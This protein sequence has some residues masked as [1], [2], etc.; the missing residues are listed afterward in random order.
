MSKLAVDD[1][2]GAMQAYAEM[3][4]ASDRGGPFANLGLADIALFNGDFA[5]AAELLKT[6]VSGD[7]VGGNKRLLGR[8]YLAL[9]E[10]RNGLGD[11]EGA[12]E[13][14]LLGLETQQGI[15]QVVPAALLYVELGDTESA[16]EIATTLGQEL[17]PNSRSYS[18]VIK[19][20]IATKEGRHADAVDALRSAIALTDSWLLRYYLGR[21]YFEA[22]KHVEAIGEFEICMQRKG[23][24]SAL[25]LDDDEP[26][27]RYMRP[28][29]FWLAKT[30]AEMGITS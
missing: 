14:L 4:K 20:A 9:A 29:N 17:Q 15:G 21:A 6:G 19:G 10:A 1:Q 11:A 28:L 13:A 12:R 16:A 7:T 27:W 8:K 30:K 18:L 5:T 25:F 2:D 24:T 23:E 22:G 3:A 26:T